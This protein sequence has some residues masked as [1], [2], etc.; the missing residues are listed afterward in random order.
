MTT[1]STALVAAGVVLV[2]VAGL[3]ARTPWQR[4]RALRAREDNIARYEAW[5]GGVRDDGPTGASVAMDLL[6]GQLRVDTAIAGV[7]IL[8]AIAGFVVR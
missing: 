3:R 6:R 8:L 5:R 1:L 2:V 7:G 4:Y